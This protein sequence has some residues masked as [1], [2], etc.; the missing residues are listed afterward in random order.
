MSN[1][2]VKEVKGIKN[3]D[4]VKKDKTW[5]QKFLSN[6]KLCIP[7][8]SG[9][10]ILGGIYI[11]FTGNNA[12]YRYLMQK[13]ANAV[14][15]D[16]EG[17]F[18]DSKLNYIVK[19]PEGW[20]YATEEEETIEKAIKDS[21]VKNQVF[22]LTK[23][24]L[25]YEVTPLVFAKGNGET[26]TDEESSYRSFMSVSFRGFYGE[27]LYEAKQILKD[28]L[29]H[30]LNE[31]G[32]DDLNFKQDTMEDNGGTPTIF[33][34]V[35]AKAPDSNEVVYYTQR[36]KIIGKNLCTVILGTTDKHLARNN[37]TL[38]LL[39]SVI[40]TDPQYMYLQDG[41][42]TS[43]EDTHDSSIIEEG[44]GYHMHEDGTKHYDT[45]NSDSLNLEDI[46]KI[47]IGGEG[48]QSIP[49]EGGTIEIIN[50]V[51]V[52]LDALK[53]TD[54]VTVQDISPK[55]SSI[56]DSKTESEANKNE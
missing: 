7:I 35:K 34:D 1:K 4:E 11:G 14:G 13:E 2:L 38:D 54:G 44:D 17:S 33:F 51:D 20:G 22:E 12:Y 52:D 45:E 42:I 8:I 24:S 21:G 50:G 26:S 10:L 49:V 9:V 15:L 39:T 40:P 55:N 3:T 37:L 41:E 5:L 19:F 28:E 29:V 48:T 43:T 31:N 32:H 30:I 16:G 47:D 27:E 53:E 18:F 6:K 25:K 36:S 23:H 56:E 46:P